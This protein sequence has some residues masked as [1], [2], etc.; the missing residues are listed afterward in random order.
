MAKKDINLVLDTIES[1]YSPVGVVKQLDSVIFYITVTEN[2]IIKDLTNQNI[3]LFAKKPDKTKVE[4]IDGINITNSTNGELTIDLKNTALQAVGLVYFELELKDSEG[5]ISTANFILRVDEK[6]GSNEAI[7]STNEFDTF[8]KIKLEE[9]KR[10]EAEKERDKIFKELITEGTEFNESLESNI[11]LAENLNTDLSENIAVANPLNTSLGEKIPEAA[12]K[13]SELESSIVEA[14]KF[15]DGLDGSQ[16][17]PQIRL[18]VTELQN[19]LKRNQALAYNGSSINANNTLEGRTEGMKIKGR[20]LQNIMITPI[21]NKTFTANSTSINFSYKTLKDK[22]KKYT[23]I[24]YV[25]KN[26]LNNNFSFIGWQ[27]C[28]PNDAQII[29]PGT[30]GLIKKVFTTNDSELDFCLEV[31]A[32]NTSGEITIDYIMILEGEVPFIPSYFEGIKSFGESEQEGDKYK[33]SLLSHGKNL[34]NINDIKTDSSTNVKALIEGDKLIITSNNDTPWRN[35]WIEYT[36]KGGIDYC[37]KYNANGNGFI[38]VNIRDFYDD[39]ISYTNDINEGQ[40]RTFRVTKDTKVRI[41]FFVCGSTQGS[42]RNE[43]YNIQLEYETHPTTYQSYQSNK[44]DILIPTPLRS[45]DNVQDI[46]FE[47]GKVKITRNIDTYTFTGDETMRDT[48]DQDEKSG[49]GKYKVFA[50]TVNKTIDINKNINNNFPKKSFSV[51]FQT[52]DSEGLAVTQ[53]GVYIKI[54]KSK[55]STQDV[56]GFK[57][58]LKANTTTIYYALAAPI[59][60]IVE[61]CID[62]DLDTFQDKTYFSILNKIPGTLDFKVPSN[63]GSVVQSIAKEVNNIWDVIN[64]LLVPGLMDT[65]KTLALKTIKNNLK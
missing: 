55:L 13:K 3:K 38:K 63:L 44:K 24:A 43:Y 17:I 18:D 34:I 42:Y 25:S 49:T 29:K 47:E 61:N 54:L 50:L 19:G 28:N 4:Q 12:T 39:N 32:E 46:I 30:T 33:I 51:A 23:L 65:K 9:Q 58:W 21:K 27:R 10:Q 31:W 40:Y 57:A 56:E 15:I 41:R 14:K 6:L 26:T 7:E 64:N 20:T 8:E 5:T 22:N 52:M 11:I 37:F 59:T 62:I 60:E 45:V 1:D 16:N 2:S 36:L 35:A 53:Y 48:T